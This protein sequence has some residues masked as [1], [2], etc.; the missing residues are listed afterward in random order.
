M[1][2]NLLL[3]FLKQIPILIIDENFGLRLFSYCDYDRIYEE[4]C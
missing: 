4:I 2:K 3:E 1:T